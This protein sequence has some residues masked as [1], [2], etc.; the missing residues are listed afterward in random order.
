MEGG[1]GNPQASLCP[2]PH[3]SRVMAGTS[4][5]PSGPHDQVFDPA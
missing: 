1:G 2:Q 5:L 3:F 4:A